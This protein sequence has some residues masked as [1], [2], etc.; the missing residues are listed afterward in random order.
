MCTDVLQPPHGGVQQGGTAKGTASLG[1]APLRRSPID[2]S[3]TVRTASFWPVMSTLPPSRPRTAPSRWCG[4]MGCPSAWR[5]RSSLSSVKLRWG[6]A[7][8]SENS[9][10]T[11]IL[12]LLQPYGST[13]VNE[14]LLRVK[15]FQ[16][17]TWYKHYSRYNFGGGF[18]LQA[19][20]WFE[21]QSVLVTSVVPYLY[22][23]PESHRK[24]SFFRIFLQFLLFAL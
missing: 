24:I 9:S 14:K 21:K 16:R 7:R 11:V 2:A 8:S 18:R 10:E 5:R 3:C 17:N 4:R 20:F 19:S 23:P 13:S 15:T 1:P 6:R 22:C 12:T